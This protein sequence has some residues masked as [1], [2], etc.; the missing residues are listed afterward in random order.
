LDFC[1]GFFPVIAEFLL[2]RHAPLVF[3]KFSGFGFKAVK[4]GYSLP[5]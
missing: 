5:K 1:L 2:V 3:G 4:R